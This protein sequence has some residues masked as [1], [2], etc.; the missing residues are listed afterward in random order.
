[1]NIPSDAYRKWHKDACK[2]LL[3]FEKPR[4][5][6]ENASVK[7]VIYSP[8][9]RPAD[10]SNKAESILDLLVDNGFIKDDNWF[11][12]SFVSCRFGGVD[13]ENPRAEIIIAI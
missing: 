7:M 1:M 4:I 5:P 12:V 11:V 10:L 6:F 8:D 9:L 2:Q 13:R 3:Q